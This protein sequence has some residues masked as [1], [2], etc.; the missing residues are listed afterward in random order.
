M[1]LIRYLKHYRNELT[2]PQKLTH[3]KNINHRRSQDFWLGN[4]GGGNAIHV[5]W[6][7]QKF[8]KGGIFMGQRY[9]K[10]EG[11]KPGPMCVAHNYDFAKGEDLQ[12]N[13]KSR[14]FPK[15]SELGDVV[16]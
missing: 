9:R 1:H 7:H 4:G 3:H 16:S 2:V 10:M 8:S 11:Q 15:M 13:Q 6:R 5:Q 14:S 12:F